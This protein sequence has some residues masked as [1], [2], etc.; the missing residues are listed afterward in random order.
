MCATLTAEQIHRNFGPT[1]SSR[2]KAKQRQLYIP[3]YHGLIRKA[4]SA[5]ITTPQQYEVF[6]AYTPLDL[7]DDGS[8]LTSA[9]SLRGPEKDVWKKAH[10]EEIVRLIE[11]STG[12]FIHRHE[13]PRDKKQHI[14]TPNAKLRLR[15]AKSNIG[16][17]VLLG[18]IKCATLGLQRHTQHTLRP[19]GYS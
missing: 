13:M 8:R 2:K 16:Y 12:K 5:V 1:R 18:G 15:M 9:S 7:N 6:H 11:S 19:F 14:T 3:W 10:G 17:V 4:N